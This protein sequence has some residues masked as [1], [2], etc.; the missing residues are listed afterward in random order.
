[1]QVFNALEN[2][3]IINRRNYE[4][5]GTNFELIST[6]S[7]LTLAHNV[8]N[9]NSQEYYEMNE[10][11]FSGRYYKIAENNQLVGVANYQNDELNGE[12]TIYNTKGNILYKAHFEDG[13]L[14]GAVEEYKDGALVKSTMYENGFKTG[15]EVVYDA[16]GEVEGKTNF[17]ANNEVKEKEV[18]EY[19]EADKEKK[20][21]IRNKNFKEVLKKLPALALQG[22]L[23]LQAYL[24]GGLP[25]V[26]GI[27]AIKY[28]FDKRKEKVLAKNEIKPEIA[29]NFKLSDGV[30]KEITKTFNEAMKEI[31]VSTKEA[32]M[33]QYQKDLASGKIIADAYDN[34][35][36]E[37]AQNAAMNKEIAKETKIENPKPKAKK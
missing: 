22:F 19:K 23:C 34:V 3:E 5:N 10:G 16:K 4:K 36:I 15:E 25:L 18:K 12:A 26:I 8:L 33:S 32:V 6:K 24:V 28:F 7:G 11:A 37:K 31:V 14:N 13:L 1:M 21:E 9:D 30:A 2:E 20:A 27:A 29:K 35:N 17:I